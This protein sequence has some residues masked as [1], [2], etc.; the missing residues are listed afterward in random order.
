MNKI[1][2]AR[3]L[4]GR[5]HI[6]SYES[7]TYLNALVD[8]MEATLG[9][10]E[11]II[12]QNF[13][14]FTLWHQTERPGRN[15]KNGMPYTI[16]ARTSVKFKPGKGMLQKLNPFLRIFACL[17][18]LMAGVGCTGEQPEIDTDMKWIP[19]EMDVASIAQMEVGTMGTKSTGQPAIIKT[20]FA[21]GDELKLTYTSPYD[22][23]TVTTS[24][25]KQADNSWKKA[26]G[27]TFMLPAIPSGAALS[28]K[29]EYGTEIPSREY[30]TEDY[31][32]A[33]AT[34]DYNSS[35]KKYNC[36]FSFQRPSSYSCLYIEFFMEDPGLFF[37]KLEFEKALFYTNGNP[38][39]FPITD[40]RIEVFY[41]GSFRADGV[42]VYYSQ[43]VI[44]DFREFNTLD[45]F[46]SPSFSVESNKITK[47]SL[48]FTYPPTR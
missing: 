16:P 21:V 19:V 48:I 30:S 28:V 29:A 18:F 24:V 42:C 2:L 5:L 27:G 13:G 34:P 15:P 44:D 20:G 35:A 1:E 36:S 33:N 12:I 7:I 31:L 45:V 43:G 14:T 46:N 9:S 4:A 40:K 17:L 22:N 38:I 25:V 37:P 6:S 23:A 47:V 3:R 8:E 39:E 10:G 32:F 41:N 11:P 26:D